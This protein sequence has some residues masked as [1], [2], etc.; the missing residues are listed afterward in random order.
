MTHRSCLIDSDC[1][2][3]VAPPG[4]WTTSRVLTNDQASPQ[5]MQTTADN[6]TSA[7]GVYITLCSYPPY[8]STEGY[9]S[10]WFFFSARL[11]I[12]RRRWR[13]SAWNFSRWYI[14]VPDRSSPLFGAVAYSQVSPNPKLWA[15]ILTVWPRMSQKRGSV[16]FQLEHDKGFLKM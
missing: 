14:S 10:C 2:Y 11:Q 3:S 5:T 16:T 15:K 7:Y 12:S 4:E 6:S 1:R 9:I 13:R 8:V